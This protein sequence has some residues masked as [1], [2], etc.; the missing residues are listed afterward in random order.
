MI[1]SKHTELKPG[2]GNEKGLGAR[3]LYWILF[4]LVMGLQSFIYTVITGLLNFNSSPWLYPSLLF[5]VIGVGFLFA[6]IGAV[7]VKRHIFLFGVLFGS[8][9]SVV[10]FSN[11]LYFR[12]YG[13]MMTLS[14]FQ[15]MKYLTDISSSVLEFIRPVDFLL[16]LNVPLVIGL[17]VVMNPVLMRTVDI[18]ITGRITIALGLAASAATM[19]LTGNIGVDRSM[20]K[21]NSNYIIRTQG[22]FRVYG[23]YVA[24]LAGSFVGRWNDH[25]TTD[26]NEILDFYKQKHKSV[27][28][29]SP[30]VG[31]AQRANLI[32]IQIEAAQ[33]FVVGR[34]IDGAEITPNL[35]SFMK[36]SVYFEN[37]Y[38]QIAGG[39][40]SDAEYVTNVSLFPEKNGS[41]NFDFVGNSFWALP[42]LLKQN[43]YSTLVTHANQPSFWNREHMFRALGFDRFVSSTSGDLELD[44]VIGWSGYGLSD[45]SMLGQMSKILTKTGQPFYS[46]IVTLSSHHPFANFRDTHELSVGKYETSVMGDYLKAVHYTDACLGE[47]IAQLKA[48]GLYDRSVIG[49]Y[50]DHFGVSKDKSAMLGEFLGVDLNRPEA[51]VKVAKVP[52]MIRWPVLAAGAGYT[53]SD[54]AG[55]IDIMPTAAGLLGVKTPYALGRNLLDQNAASGASE[56]PRHAT[57]RNTS[58]VTAT[59]YYDSARDTAFYLDSGDVVARGE[60]SAVLD[61]VR[62]ELGV[63]DKI[64]ATDAFASF[65][66]F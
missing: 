59:M 10:L 5:S 61:F 30:G 21:Y 15:Q 4:A 55:Q 26:E 31:V 66:K 6:A 52:F 35:N 38:Y 54:A 39:N 3:W 17:Y 40:T 56:I 9:T 60:Y 7:F 45:R 62:K 34:N 12:Y 64:L 48:N 1:E 16:F 42:K 25:S 2:A 23:D 32:L 19:I 53:V 28:V 24:S 49:I 57:F 51:W 36:D 58:F 11:I 63:S 46:M 43:G 29:G 33:Q 65:L 13:F 8:I 14:T 20:M 41:V 50:G 37:L 18:T 44:D 47:F 27:G 22:P